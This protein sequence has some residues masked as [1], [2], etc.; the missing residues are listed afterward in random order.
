[1]NK[2]LLEFLKRT[3]LYTPAMVIIFSCLALGGLLGVSF[4]WPGILLRYL[5]R[6]RNFI[7]SPIHEYVSLGALFFAGILSA[8]CMATGHAALDF[9]ALCL[10]T[11]T[12]TYYMCGKQP[13]WT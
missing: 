13:P 5:L 10:T 11:T 2:Q 8:Y 6:N 3:R 1:M 4:G 9:G 7:D 12:W